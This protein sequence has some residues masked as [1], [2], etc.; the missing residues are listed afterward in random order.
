MIY[1]SSIAF[2]LHSEIFRATVASYEKG[3]YNVEFFGDKYCS[4]NRKCLKDAK[5]YYVATV[6]GDKPKVRPFGT[7]HIF[8]GKLYMQ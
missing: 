5:S 6:D 2:P 4:E 1:F 7:A 8:E 3:W